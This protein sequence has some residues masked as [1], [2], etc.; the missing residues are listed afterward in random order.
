MHET[1][2]FG[3]CQ[4]ATK[5]EEEKICRKNGSECVVQCKYERLGELCFICGMVTHTERFCNKKMDRSS[6][7]IVKEWGN[8]LRAPPR[9]AA[10][11]ERSRWLRDERDVEWGVNLGNANYNQHFSESVSADRMRGGNQGRDFRGKAHI[12][13]EKSQQIEFSN[14]LA[15]NTKTNSLIG[16]DMGELNGLNVEERKRRRGLDNTEYMETEGGNMVL[17]SES[18]LSKVDCADSSP[19]FLAQLAK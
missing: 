10:G 13:T 3:G 8:W 19:E 14:V 17:L 18:N 16:P 12:G 2:D 4:K 1:E 5:K 11:Q 9:K 15:A 7:E 6:S